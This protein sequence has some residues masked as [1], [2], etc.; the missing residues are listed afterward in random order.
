MAKGGTVQHFNKGGGAKKTLD[1]MQAELFKKGT[2]AADKPN[3][4]RRSF[5]G[6]GPQSSFPLAN[7]DTKALEKMQQEL[8]G[9]PFI[10]EKSVTVDPG[11]GGVSETIKSVAATPMSRRSVLQSA[12]GQALRGA[13]PDMTGLGA[14]GDVAKAAESVA[15]AA[16][17][18]LTNPYAVIMSMLKQGKSEEDI[19]KMFAKEKP[20]FNEYAVES[21][22]SNVRNPS[23]YLA[24]DLPT[25]KTPSGALREIV[26]FQSDKWDDHLNPLKLKSE[27][28]QLRSADPD[29]YKGMIN[30]AKDISMLS[31]EEATNI[32]L[33]QKW[34][35][36]FMKG[37]I[38]YDQ[39]PQYYQRKI[40]NINAGFGSEY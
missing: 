33:K 22:I 23:E 1:Q 37:E 32:G 12:A 27:L 7:V 17:S 16:A 39:L 11:K 3:L 25:L 24:G 18:N 4:S 20:E 6:L 8:K 15:P 36:R 31:A 9:A 29:A 28:R 21:M 35:D 5:F 34:I 2:K 19:M 10:T 38:N 26:E 14:L 13:L 30:A 40:D